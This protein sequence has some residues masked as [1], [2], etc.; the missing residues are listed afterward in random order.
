MDYRTTDNNLITN[1][2]L[3]KKNKKIYSVLV[4]KI[5]SSS[6]YIYK[7]HINRDKNSVLNMKKIV[8]SYLN[9]K[10]RP[11]WYRRTIKLPK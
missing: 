10:E 9:N 3:N 4:S 7:S 8:S 11:Y 5:Q 1:K 2:N 6:G